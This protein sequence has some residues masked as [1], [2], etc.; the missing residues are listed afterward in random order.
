MAR[1]GSSGFGGRR[2]FGRRPKPP[3]DPASSDAARGKA[4]GLLARRDFGSKELKGRLARAGFESGAAEVAVAG[5]EDQQLVD[6]ARYVE[7]AV[8]SR[9]AKGQGP[10]RISLELKRLGLPPERIAEAVDVRS[11]DWVERA[12]EL[13]QKRFGRAQ[14]SDR[15]ARTR[16]VRFLLYRGFTSDQV[17]AALGRA[18]SDLADEDLAIADDALESPDED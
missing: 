15:D 1:E 5:L 18:A 14:P 12:M 8:L 17:R 11:P 13:R 3:S 2:S 10:V 16:Q 6:D 9:T 7:N 4:I